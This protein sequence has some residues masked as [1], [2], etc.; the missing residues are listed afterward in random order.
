ME[1]I[2]VQ[3]AF[4]LCWHGL[5]VQ[6]FMCGTPFH[7]SFVRKVSFSTF[8]KLSLILL[9]I[10]SGSPCRERVS[11]P[12]RRNSTN[13]ALK[14]WSEKRAYMDWVL[15]KGNVYH[16]KWWGCCWDTF[17]QETDTIRL[18][19]LAN[20]PVA[21]EDSIPWGRAGTRETIEELLL[22]SRWGLLLAPTSL[23]VVLLKMSREVHEL[24]LQEKKICWN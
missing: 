4:S 24:L 8:S 10:S 16:G 2:I 13:K 6:D 20:N 5:R 11:I 17:R 9:P 12:C 19:M 3:G 7:V 14:I 21:Y 1:T 23:I 15:W 22:W 18:Y